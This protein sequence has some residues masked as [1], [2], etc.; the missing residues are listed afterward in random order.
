MCT[1]RIRIVCNLH[2]ANMGTNTHGWCIHGYTSSN[3]WIFSFET[4]FHFHIGPLLSPAPENTRSSN[5]DSP[6][7]DPINPNSI[8]GWPNLHQNPYP[9]MQPAQTP[10]DIP[11]LPDNRQAFPNMPNA[12]GVY[13]NVGMY[14]PDLTPPPNVFGPYRP[15]TTTANPNFLDQ[16]FNSKQQRNH[17]SI[18]SA[19][20]N[21]TLLSLL[22]MLIYRIANNF[23][24]TSGVFDCFR[25]WNETYYFW[26][27]LK[28]SKNLK[29]NNAKENTHWN[30][31]V[32]P[33]Q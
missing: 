31:F 13:P 10:L 29:K 2:Q 25:L 28:E 4:I 33:K 26:Y 18:N 1:F 7:R 19:N 20:L 17:S 15:Q 21:L 22:F 30:Q 23:A 16:F 32:H 3:A 14:H 5:I 11:R 27:I 8:F 24:W 12:H 9:H 6:P